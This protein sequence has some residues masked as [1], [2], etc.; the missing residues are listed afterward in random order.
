MGATPTYQSN[1][2]NLDTDIWTAEEGSENALPVP[3]WLPGQVTGRN[4][5][6][7]LRVEGGAIQMSHHEAKRTSR[8]LGST[9]LPSTPAM[10]GPWSRTT[11]MRDEDLYPAE[12]IF[13]RMLKDTD[14]LNE[15]PYT[16]TTNSYPLYKGSYGI[17]L[18]AP[19]LAPLGFHHNHG[20][21][22]ISYP[23]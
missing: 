11:S 16:A 15:T 1:T 10:H 20:T 5:E 7:M 4:E 3:F 8:S 14:N 2:Q 19:G 22:F 18:S 12:H 9:A 6:G 21:N 23:I 17:S 13:V